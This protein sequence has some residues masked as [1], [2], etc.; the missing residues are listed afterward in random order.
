M[1]KIKAKNNNKQKQFPT[2]FSAF[3]LSFFPKAIDAKG[4]PPAAA[5]IAKAFININIGINS[6]TPVNAKEPE[7]MS[8]VFV[9]TNGDKHKQ[10]IDTD[11]VVDR[12]R[13]NHNLI[14]EFTPEKILEA[15][16]MI[17]KIGVDKIS[18]LS[19]QIIFEKNTYCV[20]RSE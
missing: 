1:C 20:E 10:N 14:K 3:S 2:I 4:A 5:N 6:P 8:L 17:E 15:K 9:D 16:L 19:R 7:Q 11:T 13:D 18:E 12:F